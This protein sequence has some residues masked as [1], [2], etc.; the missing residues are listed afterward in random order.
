MNEFSIIEKLNSEFR[1]ARDTVY[2]IE[3]DSIDH[4][5]PEE[6]LAWAHILSSAASAEAEEENMVRPLADFFK[7]VTPIRDYIQFHAQDENRHA[8]L[9]KE[10]IAKTFQYEKKTKTLTDKI[11]YE[12]IFTRLR[13]WGE[14][15][16]LPFLA[17]LLFYEMFAEEFYSQLK[18]SAE[19]AGLQKLVQFF[20]VIQKDE[21]RHLAGLKSL[22]SYWRHQEF[23]VT[24]ADLAI[25]RLLM[26]I[27]KADV[28]THRLSF[29]NN[30]LRKNMIA[31]GIMPDWMS[32]QTSVFSKRTYQEIAKL[33][34]P[35]H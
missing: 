17:T 33:G 20:S 35:A 32:E 15:R 23:P 29:Y 26:M 34:S 27:V 21:L 14:R 4:L 6:R 10:Y 19:K 5:S 22:F 2:Q 1:I 3:P 31:I 28:S 30:R 9:L 18:I 8:R 13:N 25:T 16:P 7:N 11:I 24:T 12:Q